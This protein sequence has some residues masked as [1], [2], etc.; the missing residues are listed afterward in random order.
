MFISKEQSSLSELQY[1]GRWPKTIIHGRRS[2]FSVLDA[3]L[4]E[5]TKNN[6]TDL[7]VK[8]VTI[9]IEKKIFALLQFAKSI[10]D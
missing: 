10:S 6:N 1:N 8:N 2:R 3:F 7:P 4:Y 9:F 5:E